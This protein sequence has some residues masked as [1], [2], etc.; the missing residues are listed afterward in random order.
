[1]TVDFDTEK[2]NEERN[3]RNKSMYVWFKDESY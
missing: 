3:P 1:M 2:I